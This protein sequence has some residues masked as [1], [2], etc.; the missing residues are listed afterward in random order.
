[1]WFWFVMLSTLAWSSVNVV[2]SLLVRHYEKNSF[3]LLWSQS[4][5]S[6]V[7]LLLL[8]LFFDMRSSWAVGLAVFGMTGYFADLF[9]LRVLDRLDVSVANA[10]WPLLSLFL[11]LAGFALFQ[12]LWSI[13]ETIGVVLVIGGALMLS[14]FHQHVSFVR[15]VVLLGSLALLFV[16]FYV[17]K[18]IA[19]EAGESPVSVFYWMFIGRECLA[20]LV[21]WFLPRMRRQVVTLMR[22]IDGR[23][24]ALSFTVI[25]SAFLG[26]YFEALAYEVGQLS[27]VAVATNV[28]P[29]TVIF[30]AWAIT[31][32]VPLKAPRELFTRQSIGVKLASFSIVFTGLALIALS[33]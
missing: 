2:D 5:F 11:S 6:T 3:I 4:L 21:P 7:L 27:L 30:L 19:I 29:F 24:L 17:Y 23:Y 13:Q 28:Q 22:K 14:F 26:E 32:I 25:L 10:A 16:P 1:M 33:E 31:R 12:E 20:F 15:T 18:K 9:F 8:P